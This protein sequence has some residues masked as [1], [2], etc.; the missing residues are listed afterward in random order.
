MK[1]PVDGKG[2]AQA[3]RI[4]VKTVTITLLVTSSFMVSATISYGGLK[5]GVH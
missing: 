1:I 4:N 2:M 3:T 5:D